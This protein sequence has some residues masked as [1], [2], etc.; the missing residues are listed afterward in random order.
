RMTASSR[1]S[2]QDPSVLAEYLWEKLQDVARLGQSLNDSLLDDED[3]QQLESISRITCGYA[4]FLMECGVSAENGDPM[5]YE[6]LYEFS[7]PIETHCDESLNA[8]HWAIQDQQ[9]RRPKPVAFA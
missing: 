7:V 3:R 5:P 6:T 4:H 2:I 9:G 1:A 8:L